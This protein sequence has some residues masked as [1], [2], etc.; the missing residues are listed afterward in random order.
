MKNRFPLH[1]LEFELLIAF[2][3]GQSVQ[4]AARALGKDPTVV[5][6][7]IQGIQER[8][9][10]F[11]K[12]D[13][14]WRLADL[15]VSMAEL[16][17]AQAS[18]SARRLNERRT[19]TIATTPEFAMR[20]LPRFFTKNH[21]SIRYEVMASHSSVEGILLKG[22]ADVGIEC[23]RPQSPLIRFKQVAPETL[24]IAYPEK[25]GGMDADALLSRP[26]LE[27]TRLPAHE[28][29]GLSENLPE[30]YFRSNSVG[31]LR[32][33]VRK[34]LGWTIVPRYSVLPGERL[35]T[36]P[37]RSPRPEKF[38]VWWSRQKPLPPEILTDLGRKLSL[39]PLV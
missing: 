20:M 26:Y 2:M 17:K 32:E 3:E 31:F 5:S 10:L 27:F 35:R 33:L 23:G 14:K 11:E 36:F 4:A 12:R 16:A 9:P 13:K 39:V 19:L 30:T 15:G 21:P 28:I 22:W 38:G 25:W 7:M 18:E 37:I 6:R 29:L 1:T 24:V 8:F 34:G